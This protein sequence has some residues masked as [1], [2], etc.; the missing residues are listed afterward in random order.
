MEARNDSAS[1]V[2]ER[3]LSTGELATMK[4]D[5]RLPEE[6]RTWAGDSYSD[7]DRH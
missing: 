6:C 5:T 7:G 1:R 4:P 2:I 3:N